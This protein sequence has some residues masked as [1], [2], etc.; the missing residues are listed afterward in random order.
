MSL[1]PRGAERSSRCASWFLIPHSQFT[2][3]SAHAL[4]QPPFPIHYPPCAALSEHCQ[5]GGGPIGNVG[6]LR[7]ARSEKCSY[8]SHPP[9]LGHVGNVDFQRQLARFPDRETRACNGGNLPPRKA[10]LRTTR[11]SPL[12]APPYAS[13]ANPDSHPSP[14]SGRGSPRSDVLPPWP[15]CFTFSINSTQVSR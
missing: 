3:K 4:P 10:E 12:A 13:A 15:T 7:V 2:R 8:R 9:H 5:T 14:A 6:H 11:Y 1:R